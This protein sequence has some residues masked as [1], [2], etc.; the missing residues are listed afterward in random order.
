MPR[1]LLL[2]MLLTGWTGLI[3]AQ[4]SDPSQKPTQALPE[5][6]VN[7][8]HYENG[9][10][11]SDAASEGAVN[12][13]IFNDLPLLRPG[14]ALETVPG[15]VVTQHSGDGKANQY[16]LRG[17]N[18]DHGSD[19]AVSIDGVPVNLPTHAHGQGYTDL[20][21]LIP[22]LIERI[23]YKKGPYFASSGNFSS[24]GSADIHY[25]NSLDQSS[26]S[27]TAG[28]WGYNRALWLTSDAANAGAKGSDPMKPHW[29]SAVEVLRENGPWVNPEK[30]RKFNALLKLSDGSK[31]H[32]WS[33]NFSGY[34]AN[35]NSTDQVPLSL[36]Q[37]GQLNRFG[38]L[39][40]SDGGQTNRLGA[41]FQWRQKEGNG[42]TRIDG[43]LQHYE[44]K[45]WSD[46]TYYAYRNP[47]L[48]C[49][50][51]NNNL[52]QMGA[53]IPTSSC[54][55][56]PNADSPTDQFLQFENRNFMGTSVVHG[57]A[58]QWLGHDAIFEMGS[59][60]RYDRIHVG[61]ADTQSRLTFNAV[62]SDVVGETSVGLYLQQMDQWQ[63][64]FRTVTGWRDDFVGMRLRSSVIDQNTGVANQSIVQPK[65][66]MIFGPWN[67]TEYF[68][69]IGKG[70]HSNDARG[71]INKVDPTT[72]TP[73]TPVNALV[74]SLGKEVGVRSEAIQDVQTSLSLWSLHSNS[75]IVYSADSAIGSTSPNGPSDRVG[76]EWNNRWS[77]SKW[78]LL[79]MDASWIH[80]RYTVMNDNGQLGND[81]PNAVGRVVNARATIHQGKRWS[82]GIEMRYIG[83]YPLSQDGSMMAPSSFIVNARYR[84]SL[85]DRTDVSLDALNLFNRR[86]NDIAYQQDYQT[87]STCTYTANGQTVHPGE[88]RQVRITLRYFYN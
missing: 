57:W 7:A 87:C 45:L 73:S 52:S 60:I 23:D 69:N 15:M 8:R 37:S 28:P 3:Q 20:N 32:G 11:T 4:A 50:A 12:G 16:F 40:P 30:L 47:S 6:I 61:L 49:S 26:Y 48:G 65:F 68:F 81:I 44:L 51:I 88:P 64:W 77:A 31:D 14:E 39:D 10:G 46:F 82:A 25:R 9:V 74:G 70:F 86:Y 19:F 62:D 13:Q 34:Q 67:K 80:A 27:F 76:L 79:D 83:A 54:V 38:A 42:Y 5:V 17:Y 29:V 75:E 24:A 63:P 33:I 56:A 36:I 78:L 55:L 71:V 58:H 59:R 66:S 85:S 72:L 43:W 41:S 18:L 53:S 21:P 22:E 35:W 84:Q 1:L 2:F